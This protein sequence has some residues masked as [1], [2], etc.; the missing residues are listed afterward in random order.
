ME[1]NTRWPNETMTYNVNGPTEARVCSCS[2]DRFGGVTPSLLTSSSMYV[3]L[4]HNETHIHRQ[5]DIKV[6]KADIALHGNPIWE[7][8]DVTCHVWSHSVT[9][10]PTQVNAPCLTPVMQAGTRFTYPG[11]MEGWVDLVDLIAPRPGVEPAT[12]R[13]R[14]RCQTAAPARQP[15]YRQTDRETQGETET[16]RQT[17]IHTARQTQTDRDTGTNTQSAIDMFNRP[18]CVSYSR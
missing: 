16:D 3:A 11:G 1:D 15:R 12:F 2:A 8:Q 17:D 14:V 7:L 9:C 10:H 18:T 6:K 4:L 5:T 13:S